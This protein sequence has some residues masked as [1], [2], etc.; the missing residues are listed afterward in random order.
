MVDNIVVIPCQEENMTVR[1]PA[2][3]KILVSTVAIFLALALLVPLTGQAEE[4]K[5]IEVKAVD[6]VAFDAASSAGS[7][8]TGGFTEDTIMAMTLG[9]AAVGV[10]YAAAP[11]MM[12]I[13]AAMGAGAAAGAIIYTKTKEASQSKSK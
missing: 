6:G 13:G 11:Q 1:R 9:V 3:R 4:R 2:A 12:I 5:E 8:A 10:A 7:K